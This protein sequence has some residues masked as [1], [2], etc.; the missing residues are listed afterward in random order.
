MDETGR[1]GRPQVRFSLRLKLILT[2]VLV[3]ILVSGLLSYLLYRVLDQGLLSQMQDRVLDLGQLGARMINPDALQR[4]VSKVSRE[5]SDEAVASVESSADFFL[6]ARQINQVRAVEKRLVHFIY[7]FVPTSDPNTALYVVDADAIS[8][9]QGG[10]ANDAEN[11]SHFGSVFDISDYPVAR[12]AIAEGT[13]MVEPSWSYDPDFHVTSLTAYVPVLAPDGRRLAELGIDLVN[14]DAAALLSNA[15]RVSVIATIAAILLTAA[16]A[17]LVGTFF[18][19][20][21]LS[22]ER[23]VRRFDREHMDARARIRSRDEVGLLA[24]AFNEMAGTIQS[25]NASREAILNAYGRFVP[26]ELIRLL[27]K[28]TIVDVQ[29]GDQTQR[30][31]T[32]L[33]SDIIAFTTL[34][35]SMTPYENFNFLNSYLRRM[36]PEIRANK[37]FIDKYIG[38]AIM[39]LFPERPDDAMAAAVGMQERLREYNAHRANSGYQPIAVGVGVHVGK[40]MMGTLGEKERMD[41]SVI[42]DAVNLCSRVQE[43]TRVYGA[44]IIT[45]GATLKS[46]REPV[47]FKCRF[48]DR[49]R[50]RGRRET[51]V[52]F[53]VLDGELQEQRDLKL[54]YRNELAH[55]LKLYYGKEFEEALE[56]IRKLIPVNPKD[57]VLR[58]YRKRCELLVNLGTPDG[59]GRRGGSLS[60]VTTASG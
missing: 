3:G 22:L 60:A 38:D 46:L 48:I 55:A 35:E 19:R 39:A 16:A 20:G 18:T 6:V 26:H 58:I 49:V 13:P 21:I 37:G 17:I 40:V 23:V 59:L 25:Y 7:L 36:G 2:L 12:R 31:M 29:L 14:T 30:E 27:N 50:V 54:S 56:I 5:P 51:V 45:T 43:L 11:A 32:V 9:E 15:T 1:S 24:R 10:T 47:R 42:S 34:S 44:S 41:G 57:E 8:I 28:G 4:I 52:L 53:E 33:F